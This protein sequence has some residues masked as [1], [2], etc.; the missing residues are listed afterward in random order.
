MLSLR[1]DPAL[2]SFNGEGSRWTAG[3][4]LSRE[5]PSHVY[6]GEIP[7]L[8]GLST[9]EGMFHV[10]NIVPNSCAD[11]KATLPLRNFLPSQHYQLYIYIYISI[12]SDFSV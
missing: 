12:E 3:L 7:L 1:R 8:R 10:N 2:S 9:L 6:A 5:C 11:N 4:W